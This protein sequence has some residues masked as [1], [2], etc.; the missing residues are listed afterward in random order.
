MAIAASAGLTIGLPRRPRPSKRRKRSQNKHRWPAL[1]LLQNKRTT[2][3]WPLT[4]L[5]TPTPGNRRKTTVWTKA[6][7]KTINI[8][9]RPAAVAAVAGAEE[10]RDD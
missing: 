9:R 5:Q 8:Y 10:G 7:K 2:T 6:A 4:G 3:S 1:S